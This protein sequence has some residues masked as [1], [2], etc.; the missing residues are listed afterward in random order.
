MFSGEKISTAKSFHALSD[1][2]RLRIIESLRK[3]EYCVCDLCKHLD[4]SQSKLSFHLRVLKESAIVRSRSQGR[5]T[6]YSLNLPQIVA[7]EQHL[8]DFRLDGI[9][10]PLPVY[11]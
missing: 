8:A 7:I 11:T 3:Q 9:P 1:P 2:L 5:W 4:V 6:Y 10:S